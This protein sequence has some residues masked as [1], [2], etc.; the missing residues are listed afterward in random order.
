V[1]EGFITLEHGHVRIVDR[2]GLEARGEGL[3]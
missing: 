2:A 3:A 1:D